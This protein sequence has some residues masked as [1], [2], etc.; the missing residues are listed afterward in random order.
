MRYQ[1]IAALVTLRTDIKRWPEQ[2]ES[3]LQAAIASALPTHLRE[4]Y[5]WPH[6]QDTITTAQ[7]VEAFGWKENHASTCLKHLH[8]F[9]LLEREAIKDNHGK[10]FVYKV[11][12]T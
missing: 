2:A 7:V 3:L 8:T 10:R 9:G 5:Y 6:E 4:L 12:R 1:H 11:K